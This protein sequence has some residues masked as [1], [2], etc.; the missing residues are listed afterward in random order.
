MKLR[1]E[2]EFFFKGLGMGLADIVP[3]VSGGTI[4]LITGIYER[5]IQAIESVDLRKIKKID[6]RFLVPLG[7]GIIVAF[8]LA[9]KVILFLLNN[10]QS[11]IFAFFFGLILASAVMIYKRTAG[12]NRETV[13]FLVLGFLFAFFFVGLEPLGMVHTSPMLF[14]SGFLAI[15]A[16]L[17]PG[18][19][20]S[21]LLLFLGQYKYMLAAL[22]NIGSQYIDIAVF[23]AGAGLSLFSF[24]RLIGWLLKNQESKT[25][26][27]LTGLMVGALR[28]PVSKITVTLNPFNTLLILVF[29][30]VGVGIVFLAEEKGSE[31]I[32]RYS[33]AESVPG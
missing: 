27:F 19:S 33:Y 26:S 31:D 10:Y 17:L 20:G 13:L 7:L 16:M 18:V 9:S 11:Y 12:F 8:L 25:L 23:L 29:G 15:C 1:E 5:L 32:F 28:L 30:V 3:G 2:L 24:S 21:F 4:A 6:Y 14:V 22:Q